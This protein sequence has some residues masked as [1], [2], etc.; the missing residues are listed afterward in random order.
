MNEFVAG[1]IIRM[2]PEE[3]N[4]FLVEYQNKIKNRVAVVEQVWYYHE[5][6]NKNYRITWKKRGNRGKE[7]SENVIGNNIKYFEIAI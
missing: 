5:N 1:D 3:L 4:G 6:P 2:R 7:F